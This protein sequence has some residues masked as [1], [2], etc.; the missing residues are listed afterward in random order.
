MLVIYIQNSQYTNTN[1]FTDSAVVDKQKPIGRYVCVSVCVC[2]SV[3]HSLC[4]CVCVCHSVCVCMCVCHSVCV[5]VC[6]MCVCVCVCV[7]S[8]HQAMSQVML[9]DYSITFNLQHYVLN[10]TCRP[11]LRKWTDPLNTLCGCGLPTFCLSC[12]GTGEGHM[13]YGYCLGKG[14]PSTFDCTGKV[15]STICTSL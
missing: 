14:S 4:V 10:C 6:C 11:L 7:W 8:S 15:F 9:L 2:H 5:C 12:G 13:V 3:C 1:T